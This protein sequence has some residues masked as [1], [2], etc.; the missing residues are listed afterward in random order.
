MV[1]ETP[2]YREARDH[3][4]REEV[5][6]KALWW[7][8]ARADEAPSAY[9]VVRPTVMRTQSGRPVAVQRWQPGT[10]KPEAPLAAPSN[11]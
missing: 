10:A 9:E 6:H 2:A 1:A 8:F 7:S 3:R 5:D 11:G 4:D